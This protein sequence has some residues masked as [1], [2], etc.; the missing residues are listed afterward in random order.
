MSF[1]P[2]EITH[3]ACTSQFCSHRFLRHWVRSRIQNT[4]S[5]M[6]STGPG[7]CSVVGCL[8]TLYKALSLISRPLDMWSF[9]LP[10]CFLPCLFLSLPLP[11]LTPPLH[12][13]SPFLP[14]CLPVCGRKPKQCHCLPKRWM[15]YVLTHRW[16]L[17]INKG[18]WAYNSWS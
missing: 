8:P 17:A 18:C 4:P 6:L 16:I 11:S 15:W 2:M 9:V 10:F 13:L 5:K 7:C 3:L 1:L 14:S 12:C